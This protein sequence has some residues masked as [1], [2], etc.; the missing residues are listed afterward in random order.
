MLS[1]HWL[2]GLR[3]DKA[4]QDNLYLAALRLEKNATVR[5]NIETQLERVHQYSKFF[6]V[7]YW[8]SNW[9]NYRLHYYQFQ[10]NLSWQLYQSEKKMFNNTNGIEEGWQGNLAM[11]V[12]I[13]FGAAWL[14]VPLKPHIK[15][16]MAWFSHRAKSYFPNVVKKERNPSSRPESSANPMANTGTNHAELPSNT[17]EGSDCALPITISDDMVQPLLRLGITKQPGDTLSFKELKSVYHKRCLETHPDKTGTASHAEF[18]AIQKAYEDLSSILHQT[19]ST[20]GSLSEVV[21]DLLNKV[22]ELHREMQKEM[23]LW[24]QLSTQSRQQTE[25]LRQNG[26]Q[27][28]QTREQLN[29]NSDRLDRMDERLQG[30]GEALDRLT[31]TFAEIRADIDMPPLTEEDIEEFSQDPDYFRKKY[32]SQADNVPRSKTTFGFFSSEERTIAS[33]FVHDTAHSM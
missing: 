6:Q 21:A 5:G 23:E 17:A 1:H 27:L 31:D 29:K 22:T 13:L 25:R 16:G 10:A 26:V 20:N 4:A 15:Q 33:Q 19:L 30:M 2:W 24:R 11:G 9:G 8:I 7:L 14:G 12:T 32:P 3:V 28:I 18:S